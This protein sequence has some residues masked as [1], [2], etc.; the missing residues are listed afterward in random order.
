MRF[1]NTF[2]GEAFK[3]QNGEITAC[4]QLGLKIT[5]NKLKNTHTTETFVGIIRCSQWIHSPGIF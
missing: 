2:D 3:K 1:N 5:T 4:A